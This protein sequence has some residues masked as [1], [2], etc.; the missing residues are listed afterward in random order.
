M[1]LRRQKQGGLSLRGKGSHNA[2]SGMPSIVA[3]TA[4]QTYD[5]GESCTRMCTYQVQRLMWHVQAS[6]DDQA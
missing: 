3:H 2:H 5:T 1:H 4:Q 6:E